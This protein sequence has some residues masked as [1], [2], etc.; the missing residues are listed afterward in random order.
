[1]DSLE[2]IQKRAMRIIRGL[3][4]VSCGDGTLSLEKRSL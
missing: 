4:K 2:Q 1:M 3:E